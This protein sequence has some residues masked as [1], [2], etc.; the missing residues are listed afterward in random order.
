MY[1]GNSTAKFTQNLGSMQLRW[2]KISV[3]D[4]M[5]LHERF[6][7]TSES[8]SRLNVCNTTLQAASDGLPHGTRVAAECFPLRVSNSLLARSVAR[9]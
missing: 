1:F 3:F 6:Y 2:Q 7:A 5:S 4:L 8:K 9:R